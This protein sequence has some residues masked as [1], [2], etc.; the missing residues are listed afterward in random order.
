MSFLLSFSG[1]L[2]A[3]PG[4]KNHC[5]DNRTCQAPSSRFVAA[6]FNAALDHLDPTASLSWLGIQEFFNGS[7][8]GLHRLGP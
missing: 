7:V 8:E 1:K 3:T 4:S 6:R 5:G 2:R